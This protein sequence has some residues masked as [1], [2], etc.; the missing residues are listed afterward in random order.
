MRLV[1]REAELETLGGVVTD[2]RAGASR[3]VVV[4][5][6]GS[7]FDVVSDHESLVMARF[8]GRK[9]ILDHAVNPSGAT[10]A[11]LHAVSCP[12]RAACMAVG[13]YFT[14]GDKK[15]LPLVERWNGFR[16]SLD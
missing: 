12:Y 10:F 6:V 14:K 4:L 1:G 7:G 3:V 13:D 9:S 2:V 16:W 15:H 8:D 5:G 11:E